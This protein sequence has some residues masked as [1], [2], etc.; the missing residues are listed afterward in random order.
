VNQLEDKAL[1]KEP[2]VDAMI[3]R[4]FPHA[5]ILREELLDIGFIGSKD[6]YYWKL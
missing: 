1:Y 6:G 5:L 2:E 4:N 3:A